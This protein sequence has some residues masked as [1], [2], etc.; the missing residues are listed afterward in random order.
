MGFLQALAMAVVQGL[1]EFLPVS[2]SAHLVLTKELLKVTV[3]G[4]LW[5]TALHLGTLIAVVIVFRR[6]VVDAVKGLGGGFAA[7]RRGGSWRSVWDANAGFRMAVFVVIGSIPA[8]V[9]GVLLKDRIEALFSNPAVA[10]PRPVRCCRASRV[11]EAPSPPD[12]F[13]GWIGVRR[14]GSVS[15]SPSPPSAARRRSRRPT[16]TSCRPGNCRSW[17]RRLSFRRQWVLRP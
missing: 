9:V 16:L 12:C 11:R 8:G 6:D 10:L 7:V 4:A 2:S 13:G 1:T 15:S 14:R 17:G 5:E 3:P